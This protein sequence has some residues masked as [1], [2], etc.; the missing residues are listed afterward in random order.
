MLIVAIY[1]VQAA[2]ITKCTNEKGE[3]YFTDRGCPNNQQA[4]TQEGA[5]DQDDAILANTQLKC[6]REVKAN[7]RK[8]VYGGK[9]GPRNWTVEDCVC[10]ELPSS[11]KK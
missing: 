1:P 8:I 9:E 10:Q 7:P 2:N 11:C 3:S 4:T 6:A 5:D